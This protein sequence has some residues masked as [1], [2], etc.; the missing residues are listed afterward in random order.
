MP[1]KP[2]KQMAAKAFRTKAQF[3][4][5]LLQ[6]ADARP[7]LRVVF[8]GRRRAMRCFYSLRELG[9]QRRAELTT[10]FATKEGSA[11]R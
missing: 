11:E 8:L 10:G 4:E 9:L 1:T 7:K 6:L 3:M 2:P 5:A